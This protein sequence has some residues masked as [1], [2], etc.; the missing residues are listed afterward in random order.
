MARNARRR[1]LLWA[2]IGAI[3]LLSGIVAILISAISG[4]PEQS[5]PSEPAASS[6]PSP[7]ATDRSDDELGVVDARVEERGWLPEPITSDPESY[8]RRAIEAA[9][10]FDTTLST[11]DEWLAYLDSWFTP[12]VRYSSVENQRLAME[13]AQL[14]LRQSV[15]LPENDWQSLSEEDGRV[16]ASV[17]GEIKITGAPEDPTGEMSIG[18]ADVTLTYTSVDEDEGDHGFSEQVHVSVQV[19]C[20]SASIPTAESAQRPGDCKV[21]RYFAE[22]M[23]P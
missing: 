8:L 4:Q 19:L 7:P 3:I 16:V 5:L 2:C 1:K 21:I 18:T 17:D 20:G 9:A 6:P 10:T 13:R 14:E 22:P 15:V 12:D 11:R 23:E